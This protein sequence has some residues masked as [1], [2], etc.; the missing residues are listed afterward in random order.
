[1]FLRH[2]LIK[3]TRRLLL[4]EGALQICSCDAAAGSTERAYIYEWAFG[5]DGFPWAY[6]DET[7][8]SIS[9]RLDDWN[10][11]NA[12]FLE[13][14]I[15]LQTDCTNPENGAISQN[16][17][18]QLHLGASASQPILNRLWKR[19]D[20]GPR[21]IRLDY[22]RLLNCLRKNEQD[23]KETLKVG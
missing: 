1:M 6:S 14:G 3:K 17:V 19:I 12:M 22:E 8:Y 21:S 9:V 7:G 11:F 2:T 15:D 18:H 16:I 13:S 10:S 23:I 4:Q 20:F 5:R